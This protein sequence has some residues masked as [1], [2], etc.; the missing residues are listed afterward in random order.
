[1]SS[2]REQDERIRNVP[3]PE[4]LAARLKQIAVAS[5]AD[6]D[7]A[8]R[9]LAPR[10]TF[11]QRLREIPLDNEALDAALN[12]VPLPGDLTARL[13]RLP[14]SVPV[15]RE[16][17][18]QLQRMSLAAS[19]FIAVG[20][21]MFAWISL[22]LLNSYQRQQLLSKG[23]VP[24]T[25]DDPKLAGNNPVGSALPPPV[26]PV[27]LGGVLPV[28]EWQPLEFTPFT[29]EKPS[30]ANTLAAR[31]ELRKLADRYGGVFG[32]DATFDRLPDLAAISGLTPRGLTPPRARGYDLLFAMSKGTHPFVSL[33]EKENSELQG[34]A[35]PLVVR[36]E[37]YD[38]ARR[39]V[40]N[41]TLPAKD[42][43]HVEEFLAAQEY[44]FLP[45]EKGPLAIRTA[46]GISPFGTPGSSLLQVGV[47]AGGPARRDDQPLHMTLAL[48]VS[49][50][51]RHG[52]RWDMV[53]RAVSQWVGE[54]GANDSL[55]V[56]VFRN[57][58]ELVIDE[59]GKK[60]AEAI[61]RELLAVV[62][63]GSTSLGNGLLA[64]YAV[65]QHA[66]AV[67]PDAPRHVVLVTDGLADITSDVAE[68][69]Q[70]MIADFVRSGVTLDVVDLIAEQ[71]GNALWQSL[72]RTGGG[73]LQG[74]SDAE[75]IAS[76]LRAVLQHSNGEPL[77][78]DVNLKVTFQAKAVES[79]RL[80]GHDP[81]LNPGWSA[82]SVPV[83]L[84]AGEA[85]T[86][87]F[88]LRLRPDGGE[89]VARAELTWLD[90]QTGKPQRL[91]QRIGRLQFLN[92]F[93][94]SPLPLQMA[95]FVAETAEILR[96]SPF[97]PSGSHSLARVLTAAAQANPLLRERPGF[98]EWQNFIQQA[99]KAKSSVPKPVA[100]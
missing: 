26:D 97:A 87:L 91:T 65:A 44:R 99:L 58:A 37:S 81:Q 20:L 4:G 27:E 41:G 57:D 76:S 48:D 79:Y 67:P 94:E 45:P 59:A 42:L 88:E 35:V 75:E 23:N 63:R 21:S 66:K 69:L 95:A 52:G 19:I 53:R 10:A 68:R 93:R 49:A 92:S 90:P 9:D 17:L 18:P 83:E 39:Y 72:A 11:L 12:E 64:A 33:K 47:Q 74:V 13:R 100:R 98:L 15:R 78:K 55:S 6:L 51:M 50:S 84:R 32:A 80:L 16:R 7:A 86:G 43:I 85:A 30:A 71:R 60:E 82:A 8:L 56:I 3:W 38:L 89:D 70:R 77:A 34:C 28:P 2:D 73:R 40:A 61:R 36:T 14:A 62:P 1:M 96:E 29:D 24:R 25:S 5:D 31:Y 22:E 46:A 54:L